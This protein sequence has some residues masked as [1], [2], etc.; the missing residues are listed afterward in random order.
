MAAG[1]PLTAVDERVVGGL[2]REDAV[3]V[4]ARDTRVEPG[5][6][7][8]DEGR[9]RPI[10][11]RGLDGGLGPSEGP[12]P[13]ARVTEREVGRRS[14]RA[15]GSCRTSGSGRRTRSNGSFRVS[16]E[17]RTARTRP[18]RP[19]GRPHTGHTSHPRT[20][21]GSLGP[22]SRPTERGGTRNKPATHPDH[23]PTSGTRRQEE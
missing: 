4:V 14:L 16:E 20:G 1:S 11:H 3:I 19:R 10:R 7:R 5:P 21:F 17:T 8:A 22:F 18:L 12:P 13:R 23:A 9:P 15:R 6:R 2:R